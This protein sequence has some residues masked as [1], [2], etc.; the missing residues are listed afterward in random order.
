MNSS[1]SIFSPFIKVPVFHLPLRPHS[2]WPFMCLVD[3]KAVSLCDGLYMLDPGSGTFRRCGLVGVGVAL[4]E[5]VCC[6]GCGLKY[7]LPSCL[8][9]SLLAAF[10]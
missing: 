5:L 6:C 8:E 3:M 9:V 7:P 2:P 4:L 1:S 10:R